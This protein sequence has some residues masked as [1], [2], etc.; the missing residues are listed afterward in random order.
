MAI[1]D[2]TMMTIREVLIGLSVC[3]DLNGDGPHRLMYLNAWVEVDRVVR[4]GLG[5]MAFPGGN[6]P[7]E[8]GFESLWSISHAPSLSCI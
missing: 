2:S 3:G 4:E 7:L 6:M 8:A 5:G 1:D